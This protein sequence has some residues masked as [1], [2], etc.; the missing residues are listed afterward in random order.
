MAWEQNASTISVSGS[1]ML[2]FD[3]ERSWSEFF[4][5]SS[6]LDSRRPLKIILVYSVWEREKT[7]TNN[8]GLLVFMPC[9]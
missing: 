2:G 3:L 5:K 4:W 7:S 1:R 9:S 6:K 8:L